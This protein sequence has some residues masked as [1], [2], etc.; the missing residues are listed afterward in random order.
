MSVPRVLGLDPYRLLRGRPTRGVDIVYKKFI[1]R[2]LIEMRDRGKAS[3]LV[4]VEL[5]EIMSLSDRIL[6]MFDGMIVGEVLQGD[7]T[8]RMLGLMM[9]G[10]PPEQTDRVDPASAIPGVEAQRSMT[11]RA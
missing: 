7:A 5:D 1:H 4:L 11:G 10:V 9:A 2:R 3:L 6:V 8:E